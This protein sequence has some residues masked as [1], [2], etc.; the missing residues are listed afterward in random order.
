[1]ATTLE[2]QARRLKLEQDANRSLYQQY[3]QDPYNSMF[4]PVDPNA[5]KVGQVIG[6]PAV[7][8]IPAVDLPSY[9][10]PGLLTNQLM[11]G[12]SVVDGNIVPGAGRKP[13]MF[14]PTPNIP[15]QGEFGSTYTPGSRLEGNITYNAQGRPTYSL[16]ATQQKIRFNPNYNM[17]SDL[18]RENRVGF[19]DLKEYDVGGGGTL[20]RNLAGL[21]GQ[22]TKYGELIAS[23]LNAQGQEKLKKGREAVKEYNKNNSPGVNPFS[24]QTAKYQEGLNKIG[25]KYAFGLNDLTDTGLD[26]FNVGKDADTGAFRNIGSGGIYNPGGTP[27]PNLEGRAFEGGDTLQETVTNAGMT[28]SGDGQ[29]GTPTADSLRYTGENVMQSNPMMRDTRNA[30]G[31]G[32]VLDPEVSKMFLPGGQ[33]GQAAGEAATGGILNEMGGIT[34]AVGLLGDIMLMQ[35]LLDNKQTAA[36]AAGIPRGQAG[37]N[38]QYVDPYKRRF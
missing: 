35:S 34:G 8:D 28:L 16:P 23:D 11:S 19:A 3:I 5:P 29:V 38:V 14:D 24:D 13:G 20:D 32:I 10:N 22:D 15:S 7:G 4:N 25:D 37:A 17:G 18:V 30:L 33:Y 27:G 12:A 31:G 1:M 21:G 36:P 26:K 9:M 2:E 6:S